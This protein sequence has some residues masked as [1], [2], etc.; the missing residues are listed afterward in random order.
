MV[1]WP[2]PCVIEPEKIV[3]APERSKRIS[4]PSKPAAAARSMVL[5]RP[6]PRSLPRLR[7]SAR[8]AAKFM[9][10]ASSS[11]MSMLCSNAPLSYVKVRP[12]RNGMASG[13]M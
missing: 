9:A 2:C 5:D 12:V 11:A 7:D 10:S 13:A 6:K 4:A 1:S 8:R 3:T